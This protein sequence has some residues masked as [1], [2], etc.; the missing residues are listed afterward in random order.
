MTAGTPDF[1]A[2]ERLLAKLRAFA[3]GLDDDERGMLA[4]LLAPGV[5]KALD[6]D[7]VSGFGLV[8]WLPDRLPEALEQ[9]I[10]ESG[11]RVEGM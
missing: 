10:R 3:D 6:D 9:T 7:D 1:Q 11:L 2:A 8:A 5:A 4:A